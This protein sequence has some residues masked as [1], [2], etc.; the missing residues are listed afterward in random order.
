MVGATRAGSR[1]VRGRRYKPPIAPIAP[2]AARI[3]A[4]VHRGR[5]PSAANRTALVVFAIFVASWFKTSV[6]LRFSVP[7]VKPFPPSSP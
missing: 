2:S 1:D 5:P 7:P 4:F 3:C 6:R